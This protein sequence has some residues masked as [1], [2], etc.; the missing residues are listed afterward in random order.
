M[1]SAR[2]WAIIALGA[3]FSVAG[4]EKAFGSRPDAPDRVS[5]L[6]VAEVGTSTATLRWTRV[7]SG[8]ST[9]AGYVLVYGSPA[10]AWVPGVTDG[11]VI[12][13][14]SADSTL[15]VVLDDL[16]RLRTYTSY[17]VSVRVDDD[18]VFYGVPS[19]TVSF[20]TE[21]SILE[22]VQD[23]A[24]SFSSANT[25]RLSWTE[26]DDGTGRPANYAVAFGSPTVNWATALPTATI[27]AGN[28][29]GAPASYT[30]TGLTP[31]TQYQFQVASVRG[32][33]GEPDHLVGNPSPAVTASTTA[34]EAA[35]PFFSDNFDNGLRTN[36]NGFSWGTG[37]PRVSVSTERAFSGSHA[38]RFRFGPDTLKQDSNAEQ[39]FNLGR[40]LAEYW[41]DYMLYIP[42]NFVQRNDLPN[43]NKFFMTWR[44]TY[45]DVTG[46]TW[47][48]GYE[49]QGTDSRIR[50][51]SSRWDLNSWTDGG[52]NHPQNGAPFIGGSG[53]MKIGQWNR[54]RLQF[55]AASSRTAADGV[56]RMWIND[57]LFAEMTNGKF[58][59]FYA[60]P[61][62]AVLRN[63]Y[64]MGWSNSG[65]AQETVFFIDDV[66]FYDQNPG[67]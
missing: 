12:T 9:R 41:V 28:T 58:H 18:S 33:P 48:I 66:K 31:S 53:P 4:C 64:F 45:S 61:V 19:T 29:I 1:S 22:D 25:L 34:A 55:R 10:E 15:T 7:R 6:I 20:T 51:M 24:I 2:G 63:G 23:A 57:S 32:E 38:L 3:A 11:T 67:W 39:R 56:M 43:N 46:G 13:D 44:D 17:V 21:A 47:R 54:V 16:E 50:P 27:V 42:S 49:Y 8:S 35:A 59:N 37:G 14:S 52:L 62:D 60:T 30:A 5:D 26:V 40:Y 65:F 36:A